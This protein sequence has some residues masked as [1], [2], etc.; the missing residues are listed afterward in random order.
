MA[1]PR[2]KAAEVSGERCPRCGVVVAAYLAALEKMRR[3]P[4][5]PETASRAAPAA[6]TAQL[7][8]VQQPPAPKGIPSTANVNGTF[9][10]WMLTNVI[11]QKQAGYS[12]VTIKL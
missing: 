10:R 7:T 5:R 9:K 12:A 3:A 2:C 4:A 6:A 11:G 1:C 8:P